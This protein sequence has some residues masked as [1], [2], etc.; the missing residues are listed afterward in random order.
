LKFGFADQKN[1]SDPFVFWEKTS[2]ILHAPYTAFTSCSALLGSNQ[3]VA[4]NQWRRREMQMK[5]TYMGIVL[6]AAVAGSVMLGRSSSNPSRF[7]ADETTNG[8]FRDGVY[9]AKLAAQAGEPPHISAGR[10]S[11]NADRESFVAGYKRS[12]EQILTAQTTDEATNAPF[13][14][15]LFEGRLDADRGSDAHISI[16]RWSR[17]A[18]RASFES[19][20]RK[21]YK[22]RTSTRTTQQSVRQAA[23]LP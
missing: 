5:K 18:D 7:E 9:L 11:A 21:A 4:L 3:L 8:P 14:D 13:R 6:L 15:G 16:G 20:Y 17:P 19:G 12:Y 2:L 10:W 22:E 1:H 23:L